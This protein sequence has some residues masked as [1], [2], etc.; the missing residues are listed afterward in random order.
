MEPEALEFATPQAWNDWLR[1]HQDATEVWVMYWKKGS[2]VPSIDWQQ[3]VVEALCWGW[4]DG[5]RK[6]VDATR[7]KQ[8]FT[9]RKPNSAWSDINKAHVERLT[10]EGRMQ[11]PGLAAVAVAKAKGRWDQGY[12]GSMAKAEIPSDFLAALDA[13]PPTA[14]Q[15]WDSL[16]ARNRFAIYYRV[17]TAKRP[18]T[19]A[20]KITEFVAMLGRGER[21]I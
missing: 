6:T 10:A 8:R 12:S 7:F 16:D 11:A 20:R 5:V 14:R 3:A 18:E 2:G 4:I 13:G 1:T 9:P 19:R 15:A 21:L 17:T